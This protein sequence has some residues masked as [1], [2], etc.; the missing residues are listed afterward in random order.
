MKKFIVVIFVALV[1]C[2]QSENKNKPAVNFSELTLLDNLVQTDKRLTQPKPGEWLYE[3][4]EAGQLFDQYVNS[5][6][7]SPDSVKKCI[8]LQ[9]IGEFSGQ[10]Q[11]VINYTAEYIQLFFNLKTIIAPT[12]T[13]KVIPIRSRRDRDNGTEQL[14]T[15]YILDSLLLT[16]IPDNA[17]VVMAIT[18][19]DLYPEDS[20]NFVFGQAYTTKRVGVSSIF[21]YCETPLDSINY[22]VCLNRLIK[23]SCHEIGH[24]FSIYHCTFA[25]CIMNGTNNLEESDSRPNKLCSECLKKLYWNLKFD[26]VKRLTAI[27]DYF[28]THKLTSDFDL[29]NRDL[30]VIKVNTQ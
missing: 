22:N 19:K 9:P 2:N 3:H 26:N 27:R 24:M 12:I 6:P 15:K 14:H 21:R 25:E 18:E 20:W 30:A 4:R 23:T 28:N 17:I 5:K 1:A 13:D 29:I 8:Y 10:Q 16:N 11:K 7:V